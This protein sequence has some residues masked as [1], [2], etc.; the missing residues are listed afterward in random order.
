MKNPEFDGKSF[1]TLPFIHLATHPIGTST[2]CCI[3]DMTNDMSTA[4]K[5]GFNLS[6]IYVNKLVVV[7]LP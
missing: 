4:K 7:V 1:C 6:K 2:P 3:T 5:D